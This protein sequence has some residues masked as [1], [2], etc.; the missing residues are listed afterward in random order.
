MNLKEYYH[1]QF[2]SDL[3]ALYRG[4]D[5]REH[6][7]ILALEHI[8]TNR[9]CAELTQVP[10]SSRANFLACLYSTVLVDQ[11]MHSHGDYRRFEE[12]TRYP[13]FRVGLGHPAFL[14]PILIIESPVHHGFMTEESIRQAIPEAMA[15]FVDETVSFFRDYMPERSAKDFFSRLLADPDVNGGRTRGFAVVSEGKPTIKPVSMHHFLAEELASAV[16]SIFPE[17]AH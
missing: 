17:L 6:A 11:A 7:G 8:W 1:N 3:A 10:A 16:N 2:P 4:F 13:K 5:P 9:R 14:N 15:L 12:L